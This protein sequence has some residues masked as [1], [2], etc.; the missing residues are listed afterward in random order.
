MKLLRSLFIPHHTNTYKP[1]L[2]RRHGLAVVLVLV[3]GV[4]TLAQMQLTQ[5]GQVLG[6]ASNITGSGLL[7]ET[8]SRRAANG[9][10]NLKINSKL[11]SAA[12]SK[13]NHMIANDYWAHNAP[14][15]TTPWYFIDNSGYLYT[16]AGENL[17]YGFDTSS[18]TVSG[19]M[20]SPGHK[21]NILHTKYE[22]VGF[23]I[24]D[25]SNFQGGPNT[26]VVAHY[27]DPVKPKPKPKP[28]A[29]TAPT[30]TPASTPAVASEIEE[31]ETAPAEEI[32]EEAIPVEPNVLIEEPITNASSEPTRISNLQALISGDAHW[33]LYA[34]IALLLSVALI[35]A[36][37]HVLFIHNVVI[38]GE[39][40]VASHPLL[41]A[42]LIY[43][44]LWLILNGTHGVIF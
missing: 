19:W 1:H 4:Q 35:Y 44:A 40:Y 7:S 16:V 11:N 15:G 24:A 23:G 9:L 22:D 34:T 8:N 38:K 41:E 12:Q 5:E 31:A 39:K 29:T 20:A 28:V 6:Y 30:A 18:G 3:L 17:A 43:A 32:V 27:G 36:Y 10:G 13:A 26:V 14:D 21:A 25:G 42:S 2:I 33:S 37:R